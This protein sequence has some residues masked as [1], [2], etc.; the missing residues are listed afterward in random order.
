MHA[1]PLRIF[2]ALLVLA[3]AARA[4]DLDREIVLTPHIGTAREDA[5]IIR[6]QQ[7]AATATTPGA[8][9]RLGW[10]F[11][12]KAR[13]TQDSGFYKL[14]EK[15]ADVIDARFGVSSESRLLRGHV[16]HNLHRFAE[17][18]KLAQQLVDERGT[19]ADLGLLSDVLIEQGKLDAGI[20]ILQRMADL[21]PGAEASSRIAH[22]RWL[23]GDLPGA[24]AA[25]ESAFRAA[26]P[27]DSEGQAW[28][29]VRLSGFLLQFG[30][31][32]RAQ[33]V[34]GMAAER[35][36][37]YAPALLAQ[38]R[39]LLAQGK[40]AD[41]VASLQRAAELNPLPEYQWWLADALR[42]AGRDADAAKVET[43]LKARG[44]LADPRTL[45][46]YLATRGEENPTAL[47]LA[48]AE[49]EQRGDVF[50]HD[51]LA[52]AAFAAGELKMAD[53]AM[54]H[55]LAE[56]TKDAR[57]LL[58]AGEIAFARGENA[59]ATRLFAAARS[60]AA[61]LTPSERARL[62]RRATPAA[63]LGQ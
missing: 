23:K 6:W 52:W 22:V 53:A 61:T 54:T 25:M 20:A 42:V 50:T 17:A 37:D 40:R 31:L 30:D 60:A 46:I 27:R 5:E 3:P 12:A 26:G 51:A 33:A 13:R 4:I 10:A 24:I 45:A 32:A 39:A 1:L 19:P 11:V 7:Q 36:T 8:F 35:V 18:E 41:A 43:Q 21:K 2:F 38:G 48:R 63:A 47:R 62:E 34:A 14:A 15:T 44:A 49:L 29:L 55:A 59:A 16:L 58:H 9:E 28:M 56:R 57:L